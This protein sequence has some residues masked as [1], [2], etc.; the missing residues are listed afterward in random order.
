MNVIK[1]ENMNEEMYP[2]RQPNV[3]TEGVGS[4]ETI[5]QRLRVTKIM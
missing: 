2:G 4:S 3:G 5:L 1:V